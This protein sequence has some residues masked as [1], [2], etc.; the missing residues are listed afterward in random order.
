MSNMISMPQVAPGVYDALQAKSIGPEHL[1]YLPNQVNMQGISM[2]HYMQQ[3]CIPQHQ[4]QLRN[5]VGFI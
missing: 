3:N 1:V 2:Q 4:A 5:Q